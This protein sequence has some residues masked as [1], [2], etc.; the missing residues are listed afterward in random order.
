MSLPR[1]TEPGSF[2][3][4]HDR[5]VMD[6][7]RALRLARQAASRQPARTRTPRDDEA[8][9]AAAV[10]RLRRAGYTKSDIVDLA[11]HAADPVHRPKKRR[12][13]E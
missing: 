5:E 9:L 7:R 8:A 3:T 2:L 11:R 10:K 1:R 6:R 12:A 4:A 13:S